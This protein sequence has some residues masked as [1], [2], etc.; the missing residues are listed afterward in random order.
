D[1][2]ITERTYCF[3]DDG[4][5]PFAHRD[6]RREGD[7]RTPGSWF[8]Y[9]NDPIGA[10]ERLIDSDGS[11]ACELSRTAWSLAIAGAEHAKTTTPTRFQGQ[12]EDVETGLYYNRWRYYDGASGRFIS[13]DPAELQGGMNAFR[14]PRNLQSWIDPLGLEEQGRAGVRIA[15]EGGVRI[16]S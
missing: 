5:E 10:P 11:V 8:H 6:T 16:Q 9:V 1:P 4:F 14:A 7:L 12:Y 13:A 2:I 15:D 3:E